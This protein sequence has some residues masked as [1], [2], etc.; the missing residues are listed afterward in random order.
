ME[1]RSGAPKGIKG[2]CVAEF[3]GCDEEEAVGSDEGSVGLLLGLEGEGGKAKP[4]IGDGVEGEGL[5]HLG[6]D[7]VDSVEEEP[8]L[9]MVGVVM[10]DGGEGRR[11]DDGIPELADSGGA[12]EIGDW[13]EGEDE[14]D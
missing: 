10:G 1:R 5:V 2:S 3:G 7:V 13:K 11:R 9:V 8:W 6:G 4:S 12:Y 14:L